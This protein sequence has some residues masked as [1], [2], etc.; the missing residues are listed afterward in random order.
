MRR[1]RSAS[2]A[3]VNSSPRPTTMRCTLAPVAPRAMRRPSSRRRCVTAEDRTPYNPMHASTSARA[4]NVASSVRTCRRSATFRSIISSICAPTTTGCS[5]S[6]AAITRRTAGHDGKGVSGRAHDQFPGLPGGLGGG[7]IDAGF[8]GQPRTRT[9]G[10]LSP[11]QPPCATPPDCS[12]GD[13]N[14]VPDG[15]LPGPVLSREG[16]IHD[17]HG[18]RGRTI[19][20]IEEP[21][22]AQPCTQNLE[23][24]VCNH[25]VHCVAGIVHI[26][27][28]GPPP[29]TPRYRRGFRTEGWMHSRLPTHPGSARTPSITRPAKANLAATS[30]YFG[31]STVRN[32]NR[33]LD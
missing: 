7:L 1:G 18:S 3:A 2:P 15:A 33:W 10:R 26:Q 32:V 12:A 9:R 29:D 14:A 24:I 22:F 11:R 19:A 6:T 28:D 27:L 17:N 16:L 31:G 13:G 21:P 23:V 25:P 5:G 30:R 20:T 8:H 4:A